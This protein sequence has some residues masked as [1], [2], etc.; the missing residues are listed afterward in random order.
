MPHTGGQ[1][2]KLSRDLANVRIQLK[3]GRTRGVTPHDLTHDEI[4]ALE[5]KR[6][7]LLAD[8]QRQAKERS[9]AR[10]NSHTTTA[11]NNA[12]DRI[13][14]SQLPSNQCIEAIAAV[15]VNG[16]AAPRPK[17]LTA[18]QRLAQI[19]QSKSILTTEE[20]EVREERRN[21]RVQAAEDREKRMNA[22]KASRKERQA[23]TQKPPA[24]TQE[25]IA[26]SAADVETP[27]KCEATIKR[28]KRKGEACG[29]RMPCKRHQ[30]SPNQSSV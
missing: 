6:D 30:S 20:D 16:K 24:P 22:V 15:L 8:M 9:V 25:T 19:R 4:E 14:E 1:N 18:Q 23:K 21:E 5:N 10:I 26:P 29:G 13:I 2:S 3:S 27:P 17:G 12:A 28:G 11:I 7:N